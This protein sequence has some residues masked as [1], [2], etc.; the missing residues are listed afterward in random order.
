MA[1]LN[2]ENEGDVVGYCTATI[3][4]QNYLLTAGH[5]VE[6]YEELRGAHVLL[7]SANVENAQRHELVPEDAIKHPAY[8]SFLGTAI[9]D[10]GLLK[11][12]EHWF[13]KSG[14]CGKA[15]NSKECV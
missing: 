3:V 11:V 9:N 7:G 5:C 13:A 4:S 12:S 2:F 6:K 8:K 1:R 14:C 10:I 15:L